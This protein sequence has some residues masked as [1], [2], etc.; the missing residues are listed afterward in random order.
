MVSRG[1]TFCGVPDILVRVEK[2]EDFQ[3]AAE[4]IQAVFSYQITNRKGLAPGTELPY[5]DKSVFK[6]TL[7]PQVEVPFPVFGCL[8]AEKNTK[9]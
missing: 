5:D 3:K 4:F 6:F 8:L 9:D 2:S 7:P 1:G